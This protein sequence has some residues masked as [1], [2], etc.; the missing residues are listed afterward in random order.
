M[1]C[2]GGDEDEDV[3]VGYGMLGWVG[4]LVLYVFGGSGSGFKER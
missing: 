1:G 4:S 3:D 2:G